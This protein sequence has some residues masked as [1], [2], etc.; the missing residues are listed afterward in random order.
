MQDFPLLAYCSIAIASLIVFTRFI[1]KC[2]CENSINYHSIHPDYHVQTIQETKQ[3]IIIL[4]IF[5]YS[6][7]IVILA[8]LISSIFS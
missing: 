1:V 3:K 6:F 5:V 8:S 2:I 7:F 4:K